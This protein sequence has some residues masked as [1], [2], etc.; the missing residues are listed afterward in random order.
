M[1][2]RGIMKKERLI[3]GVNNVKNASFLGKSMCVSV[4]IF[5]V[6]VHA[7]MYTVHHTHTHTLMCQS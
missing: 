1:M 7:F 4:S 5:T 6:C 3:Y 2:R